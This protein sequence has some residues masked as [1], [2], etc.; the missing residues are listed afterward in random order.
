MSV[1]ASVQVCKTFTHPQLC[2][3][4]RYSARLKAAWDEFVAKAKNSTFLFRRDYME[5]HADSF[6]DHSLMLYEGSKLV[7][8]LPANLYGDGTLVSHQGLTYGG[9]GVDSGK[10]FGPRWSSVFSP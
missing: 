6:S 9:G 3:V 4:Q 7:A 2:E 1:V 8:V 5:Y 10:T